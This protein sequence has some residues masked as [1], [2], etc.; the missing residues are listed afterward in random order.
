MKCFLHLTLKRDLLNVV[1]IS[2]G[3]EFQILAPI[4]FL[5]PRNLGHIDYL[6]KPLM[7]A[8]LPHAWRKYRNSLEF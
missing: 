1:W 5:S 3:K 8:S 7:P 2:S 4:L 6:A